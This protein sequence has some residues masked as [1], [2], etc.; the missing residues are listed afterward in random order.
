MASSDSGE[1]ASGITITK[2]RKGDIVEALEVL[3]SAIR[4]DILEG[5]ERPF[6]QL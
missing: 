6:Y 2:R 3:R 1:R 4:N 5:S